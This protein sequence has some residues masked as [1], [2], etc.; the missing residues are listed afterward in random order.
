VAFNRPKKANAALDLTI[1]E[2]DARRGNL[3]G[4]PA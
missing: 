3:Y 2:H 1:V 4:S